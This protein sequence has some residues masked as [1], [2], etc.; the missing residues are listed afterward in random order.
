MYRDLMIHS[1]KAV[2]ERAGGTLGHS[3]LAAKVWLGS[4]M[5]LR[6]S[7]QGR[8]P[9]PIQQL[10]CSPCTLTT[11]QQG[12]QQP[13]R[14]VPNFLIFFCLALPRVRSKGSLSKPTH[15]N[16]AICLPPHPDLI[17]S[18]PYPN[19]V[20]SAS[21]LSQPIHPDPS[22]P[23]PPSACLCLLPQCL[24]PPGPSPSLLFPVE[25]Q[26]A[27]ASH[28]FAFRRQGSSFALLRHPLHP[29]PPFFLFS[30]PPTRR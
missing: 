2:G 10:P 27:I 19:L 7:G 23:P 25:F 12:A 15:P 28:S 8:R 29:P 9:K 3:R 14:R 1:V 17:L 6:R 16:A 24:P 26:R 5:Q 13:Q 22:R 11:R 4:G 20:L 18:W 30:S 21:S